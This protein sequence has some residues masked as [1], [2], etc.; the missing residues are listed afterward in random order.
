MAVSFVWF[1]IGY[2]LLY[3]QRE[4]TYQQALRDFGIEVPLADIEKE[5]HL[6]DKLFMR[7]YPGFFLTPREVFMPSYLGIMNYHLK[8]S[9]N[10]CELD[11]HWESIKTK[12]DNYWLPFEGVSDVMEALKQKSIGLGII[13]NWD[14][15]ARDILTAAGLIDYFDHIIISCEVDCSKPDPAIF[16]LALQTAAV[17]ARNCL[18]I[19]DNYYDDAL[20]SRK[21]GVPALIINHLLSEL[22]ASFDVTTMYRCVIIQ[23]LTRVNVKVCAFSTLSVQET[24]ELHPVTETSDPLI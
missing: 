3:M 6:T 1:D 19:G 17:I 7:E 14:C 4:T 22:L 11:A 8:I 9:L 15:T 2:T 18:Y 23:C 10:V 13:S 21:V 24:L 5:F 16:N 12:M 20:G